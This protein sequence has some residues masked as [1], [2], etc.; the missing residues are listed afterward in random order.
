M[1][2]FG[3]LPEL[4]NHSAGTRHLLGSRAALEEQPAKLKGLL[5]GFKGVGFNKVWR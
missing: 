2:E 1:S 5:K 3:I 4:V